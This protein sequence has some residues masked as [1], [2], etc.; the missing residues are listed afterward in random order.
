MNVIRILL[1]EDHFLARTALISI[2]S[3]REEMK[4]VAIAENGADAITQYFQHH[5][6]VTVMDLRLPRTSGLEAIRAIRSGDPGAR[7]LVLTNYD[8]SED[9]YRALRAGASGYL[10]KDTS[11]AELLNAIHA[12]S[13][14]ARY[15]P[16]DVR[17]RLAERAS[18]SDLTPRELEVLALLTHGG[19]NREIRAAQYC[20]E[21][22]QHSCKQYSEQAGRIRSNSSRHCRHSTWTC[23]FGVIR[24]APIATARGILHEQTSSTEFPSVGKLPDAHSLDAGLLFVK[25]LRPDF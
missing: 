12:T 4:I 14:G 19:N 6:D 11:R 20:R 2:V 21:D 8:G 17:N 7:I 23:P 25:V 5:P 13:R 1:V 18:G 16:E 24:S 3:R 22:D 10:V 9:I 15:I